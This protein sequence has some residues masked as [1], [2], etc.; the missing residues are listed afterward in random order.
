MANRDG[1]RSLAGWRIVGERGTM[2]QEAS[3]LVEARYSNGSAI[4]AGVFL[5]NAGLGA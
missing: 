5:S 4:A 1:H 3:P 2:G